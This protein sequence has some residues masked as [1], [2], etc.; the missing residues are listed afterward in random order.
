VH[1][2]SIREE[3]A[4]ITKGRSWARGLLKL[5]LG[6]ELSR[7]SALSLAA[8]G[9]S[10]VETSV[11]TKT[12][13]GKKRVAAKGIKQTKVRTRNHME[14]NE[15]EG[16]GS[17]EKTYTRQMTFSQLYL[18]ARALRVGSRAPPRRRRTR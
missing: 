11:A 2:R 16:E 10:G 14:K 3:G 15:G 7:V 17:E 9:G 5:L 8:V 18:L 4:R 13:Q 1:L 6:S 12:T